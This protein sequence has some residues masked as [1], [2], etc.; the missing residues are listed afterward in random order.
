VDF[1]GVG[2]LRLSPDS[3]AGRHLAS[4]AV[5]GVEGR[6]RCIVTERDFDDVFRTSYPRLVRLLTAATSDAELA[7]DCVQ[8]A[9]ARANARWRKIG[10]YEDP[11]GWVRRVAIN[12][13]KDHARRTARR[14]KADDRLL[15]Q[16]HVD[17]QAGLPPEQPLDL[18]A[19]LRSLPPQQ[20]MAVALH[21]IEGLS[22]REA[23]AEMGLSEGAVKFHLHSG[24]ERLRRVLDVARES[25]R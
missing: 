10:A 21:Y 3:V 12:L 2:T 22:I 8:E 15:A 13:V 7:A 9:F 16:G 17:A 14:R 25:D 19:E 18:L 20:R 24:R 4:P 1:A 23:A 11:V 5:A 6:E